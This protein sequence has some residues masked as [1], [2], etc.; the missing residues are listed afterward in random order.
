MKRVF[1]GVFISTSLQEKIERYIAQ[2]KIAVRWIKPKNWH[3]TLYFIGDLTNDSIDQLA[4]KLEDIQQLSKFELSFDKI[5]FAPFKRQPTMIWALYKVDPKFDEFV[6]AICSSLK[7]ALPDQAERFPEPRLPNYP[8]ITLA[9][10]K[11]ASVSKQKLSS[12]KLPDLLINRFQLIE[13]ELTP[14]G[15]VYKVIKEYQFQN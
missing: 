3:L 10:F 5:S 11:D 14:T 15:S 2:Q 9:R 6:A 12:I 13:S 1:L 4:S 7:L 8:H